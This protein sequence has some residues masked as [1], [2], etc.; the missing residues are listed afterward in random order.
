L[1]CETFTA[2]PPAPQN[3]KQTVYSGYPLITTCSAL[4]LSAHVFGF[5][6]AV[7]Q[8]SNRAMLKHH[9]GAL[10]TWFPM[11]YGWADFGKGLAI[12]MRQ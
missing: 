9:G 8:S 11:V 7:P 1:N 5:G 12:L 6:K 2:L 10:F 4:W 3:S